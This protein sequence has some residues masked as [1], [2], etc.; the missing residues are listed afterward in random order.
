MTKWT[1]KLPTHS[2]SILA[3]PALRLYRYILAVPAVHFHR[4]SAWLLSRLLNLVICQHAERVFIL[5][6]AVDATDGGKAWCVD[7][8]PVT[9]LHNKI[10]VER[11][12]VNHR[13]FFIQA[14]YAPVLGHVDFSSTV[15][16]GDDPFIGRPG[17][18]QSRGRPR[19]S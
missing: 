7:C 11:I 16:T 10:T 9:G 4:H 3:H 1:T 6:D 19:L 17:T 5:D 8:Y 15:A 2:P 18:R 12:K 14:M 13:V